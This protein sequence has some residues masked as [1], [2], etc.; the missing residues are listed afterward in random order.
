MSVLLIICH[1]LHAEENWMEGLNVKTRN[2]LVQLGIRNPEDLAKRTEAELFRKLGFSRTSLE[3]LKAYLSERELP[4]IGSALVVSDFSVENWMR[5]LNG[6]T[7]NLLV[8]LRIRSP[9]DLAKRTEAELLR[10]PGFGRTSLEEL[11][12]YL[13]VRG[14]PAIGSKIG[15]NPKLI[16]SL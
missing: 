12:A 14:L 15:C 13:S 16:N 3:K 1:T 11:K 8:R 4:A 5:G 7:R 2:N 6:R 9:E 10:N